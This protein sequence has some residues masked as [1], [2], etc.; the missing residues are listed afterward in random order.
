MPR[1]NTDRPD[2]DRRAALR[3][4]IEAGEALVGIIG[5][6]YVG[7]PLARAFVERGVSVLGFDTD[8]SK[9]L[10]GSPGARATSATSA[11]RSSAAMPARRPVRRD[12]DDFATASAGLTP[13]SSASPPASPRRTGSPKP[14]V[15]DRLGPRRRRATPPGSARH[16]REHDLSRHDPGRRP[17]D[18]R[19]ER[20][21]RRPRLLPRLQPRAPRIPA[22]PTYSRPD[23]P[24]RSSAALTRRAWSWPRCS[25]P[26]SS[27]ASSPSPR[28]R[29]PRRARSWRTRIGP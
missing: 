2:R 25:T 17:A 9:V 24:P 28:P 8:A 27:S 23:H 20:P 3:A 22:N 6:G 4:R 14:V 1:D 19:G 15:R 11:T 21:R 10:P 26:A 5:L 12:H 18:P 7:L 29:S 16:P 13:S